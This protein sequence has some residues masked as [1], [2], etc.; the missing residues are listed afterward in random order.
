MLARRAALT[1]TPAATLTVT[2]ATPGRLA[3]AGALAPAAVAAAVARALAGAHASAVAVALSGAGLSADASL[4]RLAA[5]AVAAALTGA[6]S[7]TCAL[8][9][10]G[11]AAAMGMLSLDSAVMPRRA[12]IRTDASLTTRNQDVPGVGR[13]D[14]CLCIGDACIA[15]LSAG[16]CGEHGKHEQDDEHEILHYGHSFRSGH[17]PAN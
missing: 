7:T 9:G 5:L 6:L 11:M 13:F 14:L 15:L 1:R 16:D 3:F 4:F 8:T 10:A 2:G 12:L 17:Q